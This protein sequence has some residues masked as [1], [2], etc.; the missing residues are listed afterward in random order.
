MYKISIYGCAM[1]KKLVCQ[2]VKGKVHVRRWPAFNWFW[3]GLAVGCCEQCNGSAM[4]SGKFLEAL[5]NRQFFKNNFAPLRQSNMWDCYSCLKLLCP[6]STLEARSPNCEKRLLA[7][8]CLSVCPSFLPHGTAGSYWTDFHEMCWIF[9]KICRE[10]SS[11][12]KI[13]QWLTGAL[14]EDRYTFIITSRSVLLRIK[15]VSDKNCRWNQNTCFM[16][17]SALKIVSFMT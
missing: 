5:S 16:L 6:H 4:K 2:L 3:T 1:F 11:F 17:N 9:S 12:I 8:S 13:W 15:N 14:H 7:S 10:N